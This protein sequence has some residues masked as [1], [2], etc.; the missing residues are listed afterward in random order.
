M[1]TSTINFSFVNAPQRKRSTGRKRK[2]TNNYE[3]DTSIPI[4]YDEI[5]SNKISFNV[6]SSRFPDL[7]Y[8]VQLTTNNGLHFECNCGDQYD[9]PRR[10]RCKHISAVFANIV[11]LFVLSHDGKTP[12]KQ[13]IVDTDIDAL[14]ELFEKAM[15]LYGH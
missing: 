2:R 12:S 10:Q 5:P 15:Q 7:V 8:V 11:K 6:T 3:V 1:S 9:I 14:P 13:D 4:T